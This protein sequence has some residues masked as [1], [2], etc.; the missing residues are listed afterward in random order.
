MSRK[1]IAL[2]AIAFVMAST[3]FIHFKQYVAPEVLLGRVSRAGSA[4][5]V[6]ITKLEEVYSLGFELNKQPAGTLNTYLPRYTQV[7]PSLAY[8]YLRRFGFSGPFEETDDAY[9]CHDEHGSLY[10]FKYGSEIL[11]EPAPTSAKQNAPTIAEKEAIEKAS[12]FIEEKGFL[13]NCEEVDVNNTGKTFEITFINR[14]GNIKNHAFTSR[15]S[16]DMQ[17]NI[18]SFT[19]NSLFFDKLNSTRIKSMEEAFSELPAE[20][21]AGGK[22]RLVSCELVY[23][24]ENSIVQPA[25]LFTGALENGDSFQAYVKAAVYE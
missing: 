24:F 23:I 14:I 10:V 5:Q 25:Y 19:Y 3:V 17:G 9:F 2:F 21:P 1:Y 20:E 15:A 16:L 6:D 11:F 4:T 12:A 13:L 8:E 18:L 7:D 22:V